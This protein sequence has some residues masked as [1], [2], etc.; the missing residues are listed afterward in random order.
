MLSGGVRPSVTGSP[1]GAATDVIFKTLP[2]APTY[3][4]GYTI[5]GTAPFSD[6]S[7]V[8]VLGHNMYNAGVEFVMNDSDNANSFT[9]GAPSGEDAGTGLN[10]GGEIYNGVCIRSL[11]MGGET[12]FTFNIYDKDTDAVGFCDIGSLIFGTYYDMP[13]SP[14]LKLTMTRE[15]DGVKRIRTKGGADLVNHNYTKPPMWGDLAPWEIG[16]YPGDYQQLARSGRRVWDL[17]FSYIQDSS[18][19]PMLS[20]LNPYES[21]SDIGEVYSSAYTDVDIG[22]IPETDWHVG[23]TMLDGDDFFQVIHRTNGGQL[24]FIFNPAGGGNNPNSSPEM[25]AIAKFDMNSF[26]FDQVANS[27]YNCKI[28][29]R[30]VW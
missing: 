19:F 14:D 12:G 30:E 23:K 3:T 2:V 18:L 4:G 27:V 17:S 7:F 11:I 1:P 25:F 28:R 21:T 5:T 15:M 24:P 20:S 22:D 6:Q 29:I 26:K 10:T 9:W 8:A 16:H 13:H